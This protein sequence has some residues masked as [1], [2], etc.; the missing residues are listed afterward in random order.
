MCYSSA[1]LKDSLLYQLKVSYSKKEGFLFINLVLYKI[2]I[3]L[4]IY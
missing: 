2:N 4:Y 1:N 3:Y